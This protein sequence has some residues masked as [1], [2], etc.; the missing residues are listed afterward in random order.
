[1]GPKFLLTWFELD[2]PIRLV[3]H[4]TSKYD[5]ALDPELKGLV[6]LTD[7]T[8]G[9]RMGTIGNTVRAI[10]YYGAKKDDDLRCPRKP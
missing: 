5:R 6:Y 10:T 4:R 9:I 2:G 7:Y 1:M 8:K 3:C